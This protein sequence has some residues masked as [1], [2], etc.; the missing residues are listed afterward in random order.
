VGENVN[1]LSTIILSFVLTLAGQ[2]SEFDKFQKLVELGRQAE[3]KG[4]YAEAE[5]HFRS[6]VD[7]AD[8]SGA[9]TADRSAA[10]SDLGH[11][12]LKE[13][14]FAE[15]E[16]FFDRALEIAR[17]SPGGENNLPVLLNN[18]G[19]LYSMTGRY[20]RSESLLNEAKK[21]TEQKLGPE[22]PPMSEIMNNFGILYWV[23]D[24]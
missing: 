17:S 6:A 19:A 18:L 22:Q 7:L 16:K 5:R 3:A 8:A 14:R 11:L 4:N 23:T 15:S 12:L 20:A 1:V 2:D 21:L 10:F 9:S 13:D 24:K